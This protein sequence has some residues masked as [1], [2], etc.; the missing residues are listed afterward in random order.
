MITFPN[1]TRSSRLETISSSFV[2]TRS[3]VLVAGWPVLLL[4]MLHAGTDNSL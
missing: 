3:K 1:G 4:D 2:S